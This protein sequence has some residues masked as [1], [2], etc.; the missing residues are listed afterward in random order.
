MNKPVER[1]CGTMALHAHTAAISEQYVR[2]RLWS[3]AQR[4][5]MR[6][7][8][9]TEVIRIPVVVHV[10]YHADVEN[11][12]D[13]QVHG[14]IEALNRDFNA[15]NADLENTPEPFRPSVGNPR[16]EFALAVRDP[17]GRPTTGITRTYT[18]IPTFPSLL[19]PNVFRS[20]LIDRELKV[21][22]TGVTPWP[23]DQ[24]LNLWVCNMDRKPLGYATFPGMRADRDGV[25]VDYQCFGIGGTAVAPFDQGRTAVHEVGHWLDLL[26]IWGDDDGGCEGSDNVADTPNQ[27]NSNF[28]RPTFPRITC[29]NGPHGDMFMNFM[30]YVY[31]DAMVMFTAGQVDRMDGALF[32]LRVAILSSPALTPPTT[33]GL[34]TLRSIA[35]SLQLLAAGADPVVFDGVT[36]RRVSDGSNKDDA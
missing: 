10:V 7:A 18:S 11:V 3:E 34:E 35:S 25:V 19:I 21:S 15:R 17:Y 32:G 9:R 27:A 4:S 31:D 29:T 24:Y 16:I 26:H 30:D 2:E 33:P 5:E 8:P 13:E 28:R 6:L 20:V 36:W 1:Q 23:R 12:S 22:A 14:Q